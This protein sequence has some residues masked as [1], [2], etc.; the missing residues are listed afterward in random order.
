MH[1]YTS[2]TCNSRQDSTNVALSKKGIIKALAYVNITNKDELWQTAKH[3]LQFYCCTQKDLQHN[4]YS[5]SSLVLPTIA[6]KGDEL[7]NVTVVHSTNAIAIA[8]E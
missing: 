2:S 5:M 8:I 1:S 3:V 7:G 6:R 4:I